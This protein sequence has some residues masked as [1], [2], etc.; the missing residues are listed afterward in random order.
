M[1]VF[2]LSRS[3][4]RTN[5][6]LTSVQKHNFF[7]SLQTCEYRVRAA[8]RR[9]GGCVWVAV[10][11]GCGVDCPVACRI[12]VFWWSCRIALCR[13][14][15]GRAFV[16]PPPLRAAHPPPH[17]WAAARTRRRTSRRSRGR[18]PSRCWRCSTAGCWTCSCSAPCAP[19]PSAAPTA[20]WAGEGGR[21]PQELWAG[22][23]TRGF[24]E[25]TRMAG[26]CRV[27]SR[28]EYSDS[29]FASLLPADPVIFLPL[30]RGRPSEEKL[31]L[32]SIS[33]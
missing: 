9:V 21:G 3:Y 7:S 33:M 17:A 25:G 13:T 16:R 28:G 11:F 23:Q 26:L 1:S 12:F 22:S 14:A 32:V 5:F 30:L 18:T 20:S 31:L 19:P 29:P 8:S 2:F 6:C 15:D 24:V 27:A 4:N 10:G